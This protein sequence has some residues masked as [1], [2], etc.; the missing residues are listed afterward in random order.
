[1]VGKVNWTAPPVAIEIG[2]TYNNRDGR[3]FEITGYN[4]SLG[5]FVSRC[6]KNW[7]YNGSYW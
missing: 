5:V 7:D 6:G 3:V 2:K 4:P 1:M